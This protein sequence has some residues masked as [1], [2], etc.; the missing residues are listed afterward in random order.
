MFIAVCHVQWPGLRSEYW[1][2]VLFGVIVDALGGVIDVMAG[3]SFVAGLAGLALLLPNWA[4]GVRRLHDIDRSGWWVLLS[5]VPVLGWIV[6]FVWA[7]TRGTPGANR[8]GPDP[9]PRAAAIIS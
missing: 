7:C 4:V 6:L 1:F 2:F 8:F 3:T 9:L 5:L